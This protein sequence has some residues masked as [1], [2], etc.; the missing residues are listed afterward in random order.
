[1]KSLSTLVAEAPREAV[2]QLARRWGAPI[3]TDTSRDE[4]QVLER[5]MRDT[6]AARF[7]WE[8]LDADQRHV[9]FAVVGP[10]ARNWCLREAV[11]TRAQLQPAAAEAAIARLLEAH[12]IFSETARVQGGDLVGQRATFYG[13]ALPRNAQAVIEEKPILYVPTELATNLYATGRELFLPQ[14]DRTEQTFDELLLP[15][16]QGDLDQI[17]RRFGLTIHSHYSR[18]EVR[19][20]IAENLSQAEAVRYALT[21]LDAPLRA[22][23]EWLR[24]RGG[25]ATFAAVR[26]RTGL[27]GAPLA[28]L[29]RAFEDYALI[30]DTFSR[31]ER[32]LFI[33]RQVMANL[34]QADARP[35]AAV[36]LVERAEPTA[37]APA[38]TPFL[39]D[40]AAL[41][42]LAAHHEIDLTRSGHL[43][44]RAA[45]RILPLLNGPRER[46][47]Q[48]EALA[49]VEQ[50]KQEA[51]ELGLVAAPRS[52]AAQR[53]HLKPGEK[54]DSWARHDLVM[55]A[56]RIVRRWPSNRWWMDGVGAGYTD[57]LAYFIEHVVA[58]EQVRNALRRCQ[59]GVWYSLASFRATVQGDDPFVFRPGQR[60][61][62]DSGFRLSNDLRAHWDTTDGEVI[63][64]MF[65]STLRELGIVQLGYDREVVP[66]PGEDVNPDAF[67]LTAL[68][69][70]V[71]ASELSASEQPS[72]RPLVVQPNFQVLL[73]EPHM[74][75]LYWLVRF[76]EVEQV[77]RVS[78]FTLTRESLQ[79]GLAAQGGEA[80]VVEYLAAH[81][82]KAVPQNVEY[83]LRDWVR[84]SATAA[85][86]RVTLLEVG[87]EALAGEM[88][89]SP[90]LRVFRLRRVGPRAVAVPPEASRHDL[91]RALEHLGY[92]SRLLSGL[93]ELMAAATQLPARRGR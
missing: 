54:I 4:R 22:L 19:A 13:Y 63:I 78:R 65:R 38:D 30:F 16:R 23:Y 79:R 75:A 71:L 84:Q 37:V 76:A 67:C 42:A 55:Q 74:P 68:G 24:E 64:G 50:L 49:Y 88:V 11:P 86:Q 61:A 12:L 60:S 53:T 6:V 31:G 40:L 77:G 1:M 36:G 18:N 33:P 47:S 17:G 43:P 57:Y 39:W 10:S 5:A 48:E 89:R 9:L 20:A 52:S 62:G 90:R 69:A 2:A 3:P 66:A 92:A 59:P 56:R 25:R 82:Q 29:V 81:S 80:S 72:P 7:V 26:Q 91:R 93:D 32:V 34:R 8:P 45:L 85:P 51:V 15:Y 14:A 73:L 58:R 70:E 27:E 46:A 83:T 21:C 41:V 87:D 28:R 35:R 44:K